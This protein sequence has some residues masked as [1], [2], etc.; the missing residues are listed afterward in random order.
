MKNRWLAFL[1]TAAAGGAMLAY[2][3]YRDEIGEVLFNAAM[4]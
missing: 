2:G 1:V 4:L 3:I